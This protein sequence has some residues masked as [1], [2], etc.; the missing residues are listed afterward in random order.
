MEN[1]NSVCYVAKINE[2][3]VDGMPSQRKVNLEKVP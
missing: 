3:R 1:Q 2:V